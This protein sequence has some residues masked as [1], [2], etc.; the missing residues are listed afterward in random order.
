MPKIF[1]KWAGV[2]RYVR[3][4][5]DSELLVGVNVSNCLSLCQSNVELES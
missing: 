4:N 3:L 2:S 1:F 5:A